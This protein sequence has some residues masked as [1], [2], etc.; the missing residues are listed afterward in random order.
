MRNVC[1]PTTRFFTPNAQ[2][3]PLMIDLTLTI[4][5]KYMAYVCLTSM[6]LVSLDYNSKKYKFEPVL[7]CLCSRY[8]KLER[9]LE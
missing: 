3:E 2:Q 6:Y 8:I 1:V 7:H 4:F 9:N 5:V